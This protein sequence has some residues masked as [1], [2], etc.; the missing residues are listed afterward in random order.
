LEIIS[1]VLLT[2]T[3]VL[4][5]K[6]VHFRMVKS[7]GAGTTPYSL[8]YPQ[9]MG[10]RSGQDILKAAAMGAKGTYIGRTFIY[11]LGAMGEAGVTKAL[12]V[13]HKEMDI[14]MALCGHRTM[15]EVSRDTLLI[16]KNF[17]GDWQ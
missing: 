9:Q 5:F 6:S 1:V 3:T 15:D 10:I 13:L 14:S 11:G 8:P 2:H 7:Y 12:E 17:G 4:T 16:P